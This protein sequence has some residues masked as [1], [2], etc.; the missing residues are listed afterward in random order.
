MAWQFLLGRV[1]CSAIDS[2]APGGSAANRRR[3]RRLLD[4][5]FSPILAGTQPSCVRPARQFGRSR[6]DGLINR[7]GWSRSRAAAARLSERLSSAN[8]PFPSVLSLCG[9]NRL[10]LEVG[11]RIWSAA[12]ERHEVT[13]WHPGRRAKCCWASEAV[14]ARRGAQTERNYVADTASSPCFREIDSSTSSECNGPNASGSNDL[15]S[16]CADIR[17][18]IR[19]P[20]AR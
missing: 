20:L 8:L 2:C 10:P 9:L 17:T 4:G 13:G 3:R 1:W 7:A 16:G 14:V 18:R 12:R 15:A 11:D 6:C 5:Q 19:L